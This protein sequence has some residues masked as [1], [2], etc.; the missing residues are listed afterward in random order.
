MGATKQKR[1]RTIDSV[2]QIV[3]TVLHAHVLE[4]FCEVSFKSS[5]RNQHASSNLSPYSILFFRSL[6]KKLIIG[7]LAKTVSPK[8]HFSGVHHIIKH[9]NGNFILRCIPLVKRFI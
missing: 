1:L 8:R 7:H 4:R 3:F 9:P 6:H 5:D 2:R